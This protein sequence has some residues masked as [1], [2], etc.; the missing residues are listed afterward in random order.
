MSR[1]NLLRALDVAASPGAS[2]SDKEKLT[3][4][5]Q[6]Y[7]LNFFQESN[8]LNVPFN[9]DITSLGLLYV[10]LDT[11]EIDKLDRLLENGVSM[12]DDDSLKKQ[13]E[14]SGLEPTSVEYLNE[15]IRM[16]EI[17]KHEYDAF[18]QT[19]ASGPKLELAELKDPQRFIVKASLGYRDD[20]RY[21]LDIIRGSFIC[22]D[23]KDML[24][25]VDRFL[26]AVEGEHPRTW[27]VVRYRN[28]FALC[29]P[30]KSRGYRDLI[31]NVRHIPTGIVT[32]VEFHLRSFFDYDKKAGG[33]KKYEFVRC[34][35]SANHLFT[36]K[37]TCLQER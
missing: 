22:D 28:R 32:E 8:K 37:L 36:R 19:I 24:C 26:N 33:R 25:V 11:N 14:F 35:H 7:K 6:L 1:E 30:S 4:K 23:V 10:E 29:V 17:V 12:P 16:C 27:Q 21:L 13:R 5:W 18:L 15:L 31:M 20:Y 2:A 34:V 3:Q 9:E